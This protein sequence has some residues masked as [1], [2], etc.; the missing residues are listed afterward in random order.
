[1]GEY[2]N[3]AVLIALCLIMGL[4]LFNGKC[5]FMLVGYDRNKYD[6]KV[7]CRFVGLILIAISLCMMLIPIGLHFE[8]Y[9]IL[10]ISMALTTALIVFAAIYPKKENRFSVKNDL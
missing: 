9:W 4:L 10:Y 6:E 7:L 8:M 3:I 1:M 5:S 2:T